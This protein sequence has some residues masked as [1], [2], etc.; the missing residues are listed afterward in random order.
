MLCPTESEAAR[1][2]G[3][4]K[5]CGACELVFRFK[6]IGKLTGVIKVILRDM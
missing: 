6:R 3:C 5:K 1:G 2:Q 4:D